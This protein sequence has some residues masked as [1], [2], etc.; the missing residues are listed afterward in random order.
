M[1]WKLLFFAAMFS[2]GIATVHAADKSAKFSIDELVAKHLASIGSEGARHANALRMAQGTV[3]FSDIISGGVKLDGS[4]MLVSQ[5]PKLKCALRF[6]VPQYVGEQFVFDGQSYQVAMTDLNTRSSIGNFLFTHN[7][8]L[9][10]G[11]LGGTLSTAWPFYDLKSKSPKLKDEGLKKINGRDLIDVIYLPKK[12]SGGGD[13]TIHLYFDLENYHHVLT[14]YRLVVRVSGAGE[15]DEIRETVE[16]RFDDFAE[17]QGATLPQHWEIHYRR[18]P[19]PP[20]ELRWN[21]HF[22]TITQNPAN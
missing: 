10:D 12:Q 16:E 22:T 18:E 1:K 11:L 15:T 4:A 9:R 8:I 17:F 13:L 21:V 14:V 6:G 3:E 7:E 2:L 5:G 20:S 19:G